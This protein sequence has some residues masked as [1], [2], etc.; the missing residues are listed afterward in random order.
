[1]ETGYSFS[2]S[3]YPYDFYEQ[4]TAPKYCEP[5]VD[6]NLHSNKLLLHILKQYRRGQTCVV[7]Q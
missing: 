1:M 4:T 3:D 5:Q 2:I 7:Y 6:P